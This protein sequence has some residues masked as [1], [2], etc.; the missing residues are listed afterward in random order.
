[1]LDSSLDEA[2]TMSQSLSSEPHLTAE[3]DLRQRT[4][5]KVEEACAAQA[6]AVRD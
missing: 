1:M 2:Q 6:V 3:F 5:Q 4:K